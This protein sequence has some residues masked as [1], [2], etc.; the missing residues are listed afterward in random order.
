MSDERVLDDLKIWQSNRW[1]R[2]KWKEYP[3]IPL[4]DIIRSSSN[5]HIIP[6]NEQIAQQLIASAGARSS[7]PGNEAVVKDQLNALVQTIESHDGLRLLVVNPAIAATE[8]TAVLGKISEKLGADPIVL[9][10]LDV[11]A[12]KER[13]DHL[14]LISSVYSDMADDYLGII[15]AEITTAAPLNPGQVAQLEASLRDATG[16]EVRISRNTDP[17]LLGGV[18]TRIGD[19]VYD[20]SVRGHLDRIRERLES[21]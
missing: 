20:G 9:R 12:D 8:K 14:A 7:S 5:M 3:P 6:A 13:L 4:D 18:V 1:Y 11:V 10:F 2:D 15:T 17:E 21:S 16:G 19:V